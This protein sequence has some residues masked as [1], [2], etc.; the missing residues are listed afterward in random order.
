MAITFLAAGT[1]SGSADTNSPFAATSYA[2]PAGAGA[3]D[4]LIV[5][6]GNKP[7]A[8][9]P[10]TPAEFTQQATVTNGVVAN[11]AD[12]GSVRA[13]CFTR[14]MVAGDGAPSFTWGSQYSPQVGAM[15]GLEK[16]NPGAWT[17]TS[18][19]AFDNTTGSTSFSASA[20]ANLNWATGDWAVVVIMVPTDAGAHT[21]PALTIAGCTVANLTARVNASTTQGLDGRVYIYTADITAGTSTGAPNFTA[22][23]T[24]GATGSAQGSAVFLRVVEPVASVHA[25]VQA[26]TV[27]VASFIGLVQVIATSAFAAFVVGQSTV[28][29]NYLLG[30]GA[31]TEVSV[32]LPFGTP[33]AA[34]ASV[35]APA[36]WGPP[37]GL[38]ASPV[39]SDRID[40]SW[41]AVMGATG[42]D[43]ERDGVIIET[44]H[45]TTS[46]SDITVAPGTEYD[47]RVRA[48]EVID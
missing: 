36:L 7:V 21:S 39:A 48:V 1:T 27:A 2:L 16:T 46:Y 30:F 17:V 29:G 28:G 43:I 24:S 23:G 6:I 25:T 14:T 10:G 41:N 37:T 42:Y 13:G 32:L 26:D 3:G 44:E 34:A 20:P 19:T 18:T 47:Y 35:P 33:V 45:P 15:I 12:G 31:S 11:V 4:L 38:T 22:T 40:L 8:A 9:T 5:G